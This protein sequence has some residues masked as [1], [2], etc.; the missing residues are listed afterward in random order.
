MHWKSDG[1]GEWE[2]GENQLYLVSSDGGP[3]IKISD[4]GLDYVGD[5]QWMDDENLLFTGNDELNDLLTPWKQT[6]IFIFNINVF[7][8]LVIYM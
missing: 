3:A 5:I 6:A 8:Y 4:W 1:R 2:S 7:V